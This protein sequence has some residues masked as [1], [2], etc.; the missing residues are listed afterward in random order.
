[1]DTSRV[2]KEECS[3]HIN[4]VQFTDEKDVDKLISKIS[5]NYKECS[6]YDQYIDQ[7]E[8]DEEEEEND[9]TKVQCPLQNLKARKNIKCDVKLKKN[10]ITNSRSSTMN[11]TKKGQNNGVM[12]NLKD[13]I[14]KKNMINDK[15][16]KKMGKFDNINSNVK[17]KRIMESSEESDENTHS[18]KKIIDYVKKKKKQRK[19]VK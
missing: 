5:V 8:E 2:F 7:D 19:G 14:F 9:N 6:K 16:I 3:M 1:M 12:D 18:V 13:F 4:D 11:E 15:K 17:K 10:E